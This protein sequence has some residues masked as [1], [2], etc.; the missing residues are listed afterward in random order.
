M[1]EESFE[2]GDWV[3]IKGN[4]LEEAK[5][6]FKNHLLEKK[7]NIPQQILRIEFL[8]TVSRTRYYLDPF[9]NVEYNIEKHFR[10]ATKKEI[11]NQKIKNMF[12]NQ[13]IKGNE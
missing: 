6:N 4:V 7:Y 3:V 5:T 8:N 10:I 2:V 12:I 13:R 9:G 11:I 1:K